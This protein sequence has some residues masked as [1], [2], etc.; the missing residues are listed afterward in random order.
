MRDRLMSLA[1]APP[2]EPYVWVGAVSFEDRCLRGAQLVCSGEHPPAKGLL[3]DYSTVVRP[4]RAAQQKRKEKRRV[5][6]ETFRSR[7]LPTESPTLFPYRMSSA[8]TFFERL[9]TEAIN[10]GLGA[11]M[12]DVSCLTKIHA[13]ALADWLVER[14]PAFPLHV[15]IQSTVP[16]QYGWQQTQHLARGG[17]RDVVFAPVGP[18][19]IADEERMTPEVD[20]V[21]LIG[22]EGLRLTLALSVIDVARGIAVISRSTDVADADLI[23]E[24][25]NAKFLEDSGEGRIGMWDIIR[26]DLE[27]LG[28]LHRRVT[29]FL[30][31]A[32]CDRV[33]I[34]PFG[35]KL[36]II[37]AT[38]SALVPEGPAVWV[39]YPVPQSYSLGYSI[40][41]GLTKLYRVADAP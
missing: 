34:M 29:D 4:I 24:V 35:P 8:T 37:Q 32:E 27:S 3:V 10:D 5:L 18:T 22:H 41:T 9:A 2:P 23:S 13:V 30:R 25:E 19:R 28:S 26:M 40:G 16:Q 31:M 15:Y 38:M 14:A 7:G 11:I 20:V 6:L 39:S 36:A 17:Y 1:L 33:V 12:I 21:A